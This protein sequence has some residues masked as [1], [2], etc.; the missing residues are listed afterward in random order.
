[1]SCGASHTLALS[2]VDEVL[3]GVGEY[4]ALVPRGG[5]VYMAGARAV[6]GK[7]CETFTLCEEL[8]DNPCVRVSAG[9]VPT[10][11]RTSMR[12]PF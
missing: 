8:R 3:E 4:K 5:L 11:C 12:P 1:V 9:W 7:Q 6:L 10:G 2:R